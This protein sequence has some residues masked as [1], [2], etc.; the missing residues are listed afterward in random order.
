MPDE[1]K[2]GRGITGGLLQ[3]ARGVFGAGSVRM[4]RRLEGGCVA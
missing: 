2:A 3:A 4:R 1:E